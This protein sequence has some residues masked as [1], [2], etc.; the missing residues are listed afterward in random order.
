MFQRI[1]VYIENALEQRGEWKKAQNFRRWQENRKTYGVTRSWVHSIIESDLRLQE[2]IQRESSLLE[3][4]QILLLRQKEGGVAQGVELQALKDE[5]TELDIEYWRHERQHYT[6]EASCEPGPFRRAYLS[7]RLRPN[8]HLSPWLRDDC[9]GRGGC[10]GLDC[11]CCERPRSSI[12]AN[13]A[14]HCTPEC[15]FCRQARG[16]DLKE[17]D[18]KLVQPGVDHARPVDYYTRDM[19]SA[20]LLGT[21]GAPWSP[22]NTLHSPRPGKLSG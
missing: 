20:Y 18:R 10:C 7:C 15:Q 4:R 6:I 14:A 12:R 19:A 1:F 11:G 8:W 16:F 3:K 22:L 2:I 17:Q 21:N 13:S 9:A 5:L